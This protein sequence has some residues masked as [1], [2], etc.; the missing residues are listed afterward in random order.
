M[1]SVQTTQLCC[2]TEYTAPNTPLWHKDYF[3]LMVFEKEQTQENLWKQSSSYP[4][5][6]DIYTHKG[7]LHL[8][9]SLYQEEKDD[10]KSPETPLSGEGTKL[11]LHNKRNPCFL[12][13]LVTSH[14]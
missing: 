4:F 8:C 2:Q 7:N 9:V 14:N 5:V 3:E 1:V 13:S 11:N 6:K 10:S 12:L